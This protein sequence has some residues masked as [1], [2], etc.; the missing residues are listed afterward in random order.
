MQYLEKYAICLQF[1]LEG[2]HSSYWW[3]IFDIIRSSSPLTPRWHGSNLRSYSDFLIY[4]YSYIIFFY[5]FEKGFFAINSKY[6]I[7]TLWMRHMIK[8]YSYLFM[9]EL[10]CLICYLFFHWKKTF[11]AV[12][13]EFVGHP[14]TYLDLITYLR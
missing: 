2:R 6:Y 4:L 3:I 11:F 8:F 7:L 5:C 13:I 12:K 14:L 9:N 1:E 10:I